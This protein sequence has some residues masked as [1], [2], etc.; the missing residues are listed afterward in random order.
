MWQLFIFDLDYLVAT[1]GADYQNRCRWQF[2][3]FAGP[4]GESIVRWNGIFASDI[5][6]EKRTDG[7]FANVLYCVESRVWLRLGDILRYSCVSSSC[8]LVASS[9]TAIFLQG[10]R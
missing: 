2:C 9:F 7:L 6:Y 4:E 10:Y 3:A 1:N 8:L 5:L